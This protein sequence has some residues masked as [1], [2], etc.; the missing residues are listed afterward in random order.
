MKIFVGMTLFA[1]IFLG[2][3]LMAGWIDH[4]DHEKPTR[5]TKEEIEKLKQ[6]VD[7][8]DKR[9]FWDEPSIAR[10]P[11]SPW[12]GDKMAGVE[13]ELVNGVFTTEQS[14][15]V[16]KSTA[17]EDVFEIPQIVVRPGLRAFFNVKTHVVTVTC[18]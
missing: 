9:V 11:K 5:E 18:D 4:L 12:T 13:K 14:T 7:S 15:L 1:A 8:L 17:A 3:I 16:G 2:A 10:A 6:K